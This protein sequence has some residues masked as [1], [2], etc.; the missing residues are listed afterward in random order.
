MFDDGLPVAIA[1][2]G[3]AQESDAAEEDMQAGDPGGLALAACACMLL[4]AFTN[5]RCALLANGGRWYK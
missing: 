1:P 2:A 4:A 5:C 3:D